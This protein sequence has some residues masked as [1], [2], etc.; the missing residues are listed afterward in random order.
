[1]KHAAVKRLEEIRRALDA[2]YGELTCPLE[3]ET[4]FQLLV[5]VLLSA[6]CR[7]D[8]VNEVTK[9]LFLVAPDARSMA[10]MSQEELE[11]HIKTLGLYRAKAANLL[12]TAAILSDEY[13]NEV[14]RTMEQLTA[15]P[16]IGRKSANVILGNAF[17]L[18]G[19]PVDTHVTRLANLLELV[20][21]DVPEK[22]EREI[23]PFVPPE[24]W[25]NF[26]HQLIQLG[27][28]FCTARKRNCSACPLRDCC[29]AVGARKK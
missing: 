17:G 28:D 29:P 27:R 11:A 5:A 8:R 4:P 19:F 25:A 26:S 16:G 22:I 1:M 9:G 23:T 7:D 3:H 24:E 14:P 13:Q 20:D 21:T 12:K 6:Q 18:P 15:L 2:H 10:K